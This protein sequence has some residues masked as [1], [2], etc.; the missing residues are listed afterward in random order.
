MRLGPALMGSAGVGALG[1]AL[2]A[3]YAFDFP[4]NAA[5]WAN[6]FVGAL[7]NTPGWTFTRA[8]TGYALN[9]AGQLVS[10]ASGAPR[11]TD[12]GFLAEGSRQNLCLQ[13]QTFD[14]ASWSKDNGSLTANAAVAPD[15]TQTADLFI[16]N[17]TLSVHRLI[18]TAATVVTATSYADSFYVKAAGYSKVGLRESASTGAYAA[19]DLSNGTVLASGSGGTGTIEALADGWYRICMVS[20]SSGT[21]FRPD[22]YVLNPAYTTGAFNA[23][24]WSGDN[25]SGIY[26]WGAQLEAA[27]FPSSYIPTTTAAVTR[28]ADALTIT[29]VSGI[30][31]P[32]TLYVSGERAADTGTSE[33]FF[34]M[35]SSSGNL[36]GLYI[37]SSDAAAAYMES[38]SV[39][40]ATA[41]V[42][43]AVGVSTPFA[44][45]AR[46]NTNDVRACRDGTLGTNDTSATLP[47]GNP[48]SLFFG[49]A[50]G[51]Q[52]DPMYLRRIAIWT[53]A[54]TD[55]QLQTQTS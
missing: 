52:S 14:N 41:A 22:I 24:N 46:F 12:R 20:T 18:A 32:A 48:A 2:D 35:Q 28:A 11:I 44:L 50:G 25:A 42:S 21:S 40:Q 7:A 37:N 49:Y 9:N 45:A 17:T 8:S 55:A 3:G 33:D 38:G 4:A 26:V 1:W 5:R 53:S 29:G 13:S 39:I 43:G 51:S 27:A 15:G 30:T 31:Y 47:V 16:A 34:Y 10:F 19:F 36:S 6:G 23:A 54:F